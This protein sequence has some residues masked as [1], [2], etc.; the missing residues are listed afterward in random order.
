MTVTIKQVE[1]AI[2]KYEG[3]ALFLAGVRSTMHELASLG[4]K[5]YERAEKAE[6]KL[7]CSR[8][9]VASYSERALKAEDK[10][11]KVERKNESVEMQAAHYSEMLTDAEDKL[12]KVE[13][14][15]N[16]IQCPEHDV[17]CP[18][19]CFYKI[20]KEALE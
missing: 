14:A 1:E 13:S 12:A 4:K 15:S 5:H 2:D 3:L 20:I 10:L 8:S 17:V 9:E 11:A 18:R 19:A 6:F 7:K 16:T